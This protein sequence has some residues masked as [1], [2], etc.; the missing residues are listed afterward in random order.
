MSSPLRRHLASVL[1]LLLVVATL[2]VAALGTTRAT[3]DR[4]EPAA[5]IGYCAYPRN[6]AKVFRWG[7]EKWRYEFETGAFPRKVWKSTQPKRIGQQFGMLTINAGPSTRRIRTWGDVRPAAYGRW[8]TR[9]RAVELNKVGRHFRFTWRLV[10]AG[11]HRCGSK[12]IT[13]A[14]YRPGD[15]LVRGFVRTRPTHAFDFARAR[16]LRSRAWHAFAV[17]VTRTHISWF[18][19]TKVVRTERRPAALEGYRLVPEFVIQ[20][21][22]GHTMRRSRLQMDWVRHYTL[23]RKSA[24]SIKAPAMRRATYNQGC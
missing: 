22:K 12:M 7:T 23:Q 11:G 17:E 15:K 4:V 14:T 16:D 13:M 10:P 20:G 24:K 19:D 9:M 1:G 2:S 3:D 18:V 21:V 6:A 5:C 8:E